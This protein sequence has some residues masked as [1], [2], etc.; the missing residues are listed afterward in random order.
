MKERICDHPQDSV[1]AGV[2]R[3]IIYLFEAIDVEED[4]TERP[5]KLPQ[6][7]KSLLNL[8]S[9]IASIGQARQGIA[10]GNGFELANAP[11]QPSYVSGIAEDLHRADHLPLFIFE[12]G[13]AQ[14]DRDAVA[15]FVAKVGVVLEMTGLFHGRHERAVILAEFMPSIIDV[16]QD[17]VE[18]TAADDLLSG[19]TCQPLC[20]FIPVRDPAIPI[21]KIDPIVK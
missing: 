6:F 2:A 4:Q 9:C 20:T 14:G 7:L 16:R 3:G 11:L 5:A 15:L 18:A 21:D 10:E 1:A 8:Q 12:W 13:S 19:K 17:I